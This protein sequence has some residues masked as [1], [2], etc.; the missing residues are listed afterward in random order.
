MKRLF[1]DH[2]HSSIEQFLQIGDQPTGEKWGVFW[3]H[4]NQKINVTIGARHPCGNRTKHP[5][6]ARPV[7]VGNLQDV[8]LFRLEQFLDT[9][10]SPIPQ[11]IIKVYRLDPG[12][13]EAVFSVSPFMDVI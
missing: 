11:M 4:L 3:S 1:G 5:Q 6:I 10:I 9:H 13:S 2:I 12:F 8:A 7:L